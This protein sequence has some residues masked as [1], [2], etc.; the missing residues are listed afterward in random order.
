MFALCVQHVYSLRAIVHIMFTCRHYAD[1]LFTLCLHCLLYSARLHVFTIWDVFIV[2]DC[3]F[4]ANYILCL[5]LC[6]IYCTL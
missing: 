5:L 2:W 3:L 1:T 6:L 4:C